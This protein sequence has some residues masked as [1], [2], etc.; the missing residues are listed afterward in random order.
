MRVGFIGAGRLATALAHEFDHL[1]AEAQV[2]AVTARTAVS[3]ETLAA[4]LLGAQAV[5]TAQDVA[6]Q[7]DLVFIAT[8]DD[9]IASVAAGVV[10]RPGQLV[11]HCSG[12]QSAA[13]LDA[14]AAQGATTGV[15][16]PL[17]TL[18]GGEPELG[19][20]RGITFAVEAPEA[21]AGLLQHWA[22]LLGGRWITLRAEDRVLYHAAAVI[23]SNYLVTLAKLATD[24]WGE[25]GIERAEA[26]RAL[27]PLMHGTVENLER[28]GL[29]DGLTGPVAR[30][31]LGTI[32]R[33]LEALGTRAPQLLA[34]Y[35]E[36]GVQ[37]VPLAE[38]RGRVNAV[39]AAAL[40]YALADITPAT[41]SNM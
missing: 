28:V 24:L 35:R 13:A 8:P 14:A 34:V 36:L 30:G 9:V 22:T 3:A 38:E 10:W 18:A 11:V 15:F 41:A 31:D 23:A 40:R 32:E 20:F 27:L 12:A 2:T 26:L 5:A 39:Q 4:R 7:S 37:T 1:V 29:P 33:H 19:L 21:L 25:M 6:G 16:H 17:Q